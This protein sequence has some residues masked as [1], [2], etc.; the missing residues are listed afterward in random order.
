MS[1]I[2]SDQPIYTCSAIAAILSASTDGFESWPHA[3]LSEH[4]LDWEKTSIEQLLSSLYNSTSGKLK[5]AAKR[6]LERAEGL[7]PLIKTRWGC[8]WGK[9]YP[10]FKTA[11]LHRHVVQIHVHKAQA[12]DIPEIIEHLGNGEDFNP[13]ANKVYDGLESHVESHNAGESKYPVHLSI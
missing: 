2:Y 10:S 1:R 7:H 11:R 8:I 4:L 6:A 5:P 9:T 13:I 12:L 3:K